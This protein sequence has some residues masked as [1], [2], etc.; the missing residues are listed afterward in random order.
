VS[1][2]ERNP[3]VDD[4]FFE[5]VKEISGQSV[6][7]LV[8]SCGGDEPQRWIGTCLAFN[9]QGHKALITARH[10][11]T[12]ARQM[13]NSPDFQI[14][15]VFGETLHNSTPIRIDDEQVYVANESLYAE[16]SDESGQGFDDFAVLFL[17][18]FYI[19]N[20]EAVGVR[21]MTMENVVTDETYDCIYPKYAI[22][23]GFPRTNITNITESGMIICREFFFVVNIRPNF[24]SER[25]TGWL[26]RD[27]NYV[28]KCVKGMSGG[29][30][31]VMSENNIQVLA[32]Q[33][34]QKRQTNKNLVTG[35]TIEAV[36]W[37][38]D[39]AIEFSLDQLD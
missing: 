35:M 10:N 2:S 34:S 22:L 18:E 12:S 31:F 8:W 19:L 5:A 29:A 37:L 36:S 28:S 27:N 32:I 23:T 7:P 3:A 33:A 4:K 24:D 14:E 39:R 15:V 26:Y 13:K 17:K 6:L 1:E 9:I 11:L 38:R 20:L 25:L 30:W 21:F 16:N